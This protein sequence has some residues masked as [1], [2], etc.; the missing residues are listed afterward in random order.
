MISCERCQKTFCRIQS[1][2][3]HNAS[4]LHKIRSSDSDVKKYTCDCGKSYLHQPSLR[5][6]KIKCALTEVVVAPA[7]IPTPALSVTEIMIEEL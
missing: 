2:Y 6:H 7:I 3:R 1:L 4:K 5:N